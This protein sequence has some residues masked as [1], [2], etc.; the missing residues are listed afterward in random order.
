MNCLGEGRFG[1][2]IFSAMLRTLAVES[3][4]YSKRAVR[5]CQR[6]GF[7]KLTMYKYFFF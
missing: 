1:E 6:K 3:H 5:I 4:R 2:E 7:V